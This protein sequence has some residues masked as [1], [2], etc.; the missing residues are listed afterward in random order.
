VGVG[1]TGVRHQFLSRV[2]G[3]DFVPIAPQAVTRAVMRPSGNLDDR[4]GRHGGSHRP[5]LHVSPGKAGCGRIGTE[6]ALPGVDTNRCLTPV[7]PVAPTA[8]QEGDVRRRIVVP[9]R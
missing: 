8:A 9:P 4:Q 5:R 6:S 1:A 3:A 7:T 2:N